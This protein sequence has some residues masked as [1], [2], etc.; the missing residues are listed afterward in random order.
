MRT[1]ACEEDAD[2]AHK[3]KNPAYKEPLIVHVIFV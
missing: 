3:Q 1:P 2:Q